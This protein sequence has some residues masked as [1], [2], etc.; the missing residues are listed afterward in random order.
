MQRYAKP[1]SPGLYEPQVREKHDTVHRLW[2]SLPTDAELLQ[3][4]SLTAE[5]MVGAHVRLSFLYHLAL[6][7]LGTGYT[8]DFIAL[9]STSTPLTLSLHPWPPSLFIPFIYWSSSLHLPLSSH[10]HPIPPSS[11]PTLIPPHTH[12]TPHL[13]HPTLTPPHTHS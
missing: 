2:L 1:I 3:R 4:Q 12:S 13:L 5:Q 7:L 11:H 9:N 8:S 10:P 6:M